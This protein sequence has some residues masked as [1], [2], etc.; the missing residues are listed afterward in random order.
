MSFDDRRRRRLQAVVPTKNPSM[1][2]NP[3]VTPAQPAHQVSAPADPYVSI[4]VDT[5]DA[6]ITAAT[7]VVLFD[8]SMGYQL[9]T[10]FAMDPLV[11]ITGG[12]A[13]YQFILNDLA[14]SNGSYFDTIQQ[15]VSDDSVAMAQ[16]GRPL[17]VYES[18][19]GSAPRLEKTIHPGMGVH[20]G[21]YQKG[22]N[23]FNIPLTIGNRTAIVYWQEPGVKITWG[24]YQKAEL[25]RIK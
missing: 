25:G 1:I 2:N 7:K 4:T 12:T 24:F 14:S 15:R 3:T 9:G 11:K 6:G 22:I 19:K 5:T 21:Q 13:P 10:T 23:T 16:F 20:E 8:A 18:S 17:E